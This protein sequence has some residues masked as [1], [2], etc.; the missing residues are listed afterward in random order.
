MSKTFYRQ[1][2]VKYVAYPWQPAGAARAPHPAKRRT[3][4]YD[5][6]TL[7]YDTNCIWIIRRKDTP[8]AYNG[9][10]P[11]LPAKGYLKKGD[12]GQ[13]VK[14]LQL[15]LNWFG[16]YGLVVDGSF[17][18]KTATALKKFQTA[19]GLKVDGLFGPASFAKAKTVKK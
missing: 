14:Y 7:R 16:D 10:F 9:T 4:Y 13:A 8:S 19:T 12:T 6:E 5:P 1:I 18:D 11:T 2:M 15:F 17:G 3:G